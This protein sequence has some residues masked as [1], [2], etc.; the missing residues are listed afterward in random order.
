M[1]AA[2]CEELGPPED[3]R[4]VDVEPAPCGPSQVRVAVR[5]AGLNF[6]DALMVQGK[7][8]I[9]FPPPFTP[10]SELAGA[11][12]EVG[13]D[14]TGLAVGDRVLASI[15]VGAFAEEVVISA[16]QAV[17]VPDGVTDGQAATLVVAY[18][19]ALFGLQNRAHL[20]PGQTLL[21]LGAGGGV[22]LAAIDV[23][24]ALGATVI[25][26]ASSPEKLA[27]AREAGAHECID[28]STEPLKE[29]AR[30]LT[31]GG[32]DVAY[33]PVGGELAEQALRALGTD[34][35][36]LVI[37]FASGTIPKLPANLVLLRN[38][39]VV[40]VDWGAWAMSDPEGN[41]ELIE[42]ALVKTASGMLHPVEPFT[43]SLDQTSTALR[44]LLDRRV[45]GKAVIVP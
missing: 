17:R 44:D 21:V 6:A 11:I 25:A 2:V 43:Y 23:G 1:R 9:R 34:G 42:D 45:T 12:T 15:G 16:E 29:R 33:D 41:R 35:Q 13:A 38:R 36:F 26:A 10:G 7:Y 18:G 24:V 27:L 3:V 20:K 19:T 22:G 39:R 40:G 8:Q 37:G 31:G 5:A 32:V 30:E 14:V 28:Y 4:V